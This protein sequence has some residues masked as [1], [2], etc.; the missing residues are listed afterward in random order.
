MAPT[1]ISIK[2]E[3]EVAREGARDTV[4][5]V[6]SQAVLKSDEIIWSEGEII[7]IRDILSVDLDPYNPLVVVLQYCNNSGKKV[8]VDEKYLM[9]RN[10]EI[11]WDWMLAIRKLNRDAWQFHAEEFKMKSGEGVLISSPECYQRHVIAREN[12]K[13]KTFEKLLILSDAWVYITLLDSNPELSI[14]EKDVGKF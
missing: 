6:D 5:G 7:R 14:S 4:R 10:T 11:R 9:F 8:D 1:H 13:L 12:I 3:E 2:M